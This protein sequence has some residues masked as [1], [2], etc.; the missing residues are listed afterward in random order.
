MSHYYATIIRERPPSEAASVLADDCRK[1]DASISVLQDQI[2]TLLEFANAYTDG[3]TCVWCS[4]GEGEDG[5]IEHEA[6]CEGE[7]A[8]KLIP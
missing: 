3:M 6:D 7:K 4:G 2:A 8:R 1:K 5:E